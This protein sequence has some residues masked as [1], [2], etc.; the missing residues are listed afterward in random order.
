[1]SETEVDTILLLTSDNYITAEYDSQLDK[2][3]RYEEVS[4]QNITS[5]EIGMYQPPKLFPGSQSSFLC[6]RINY[7]VNDVDGFF[8]MFRSP[9]IRFFN[10]VAVVIKKPEE[11][12]ESL[13]SI[14]EFYRIALDT[15]GRTDVQIVTG[16]ALSRRKSRS[17]LLGVSS[18]GMPRNLS[19]SQL[20][21]V[22]SK[23]V[24]SLAGQFSKLGKSLKSKSTGAK[25]TFQIGKAEEGKRP[26][27]FSSGSDDGHVSDAEE[28]DMVHDSESIV[29]DNDFLPSVG[30]VMAG[31]NESPGTDGDPAILASKNSMSKLSS[32]VCTSAIS[33][34]TDNIQMPRR[35][36]QTDSPV[37]SRSRSPNPEIRVDDGENDIPDCPN[38][39]KYS[40]SSTDFTNQKETMSSKAGLSKDLKLNL[41]TSHSD[42]ALKQLKSLTSPFSKIAKG[43]QSIGVNL[44]PRKIGARTGAI[45]SPTQQPE[46]IQEDYA[47]KLQNMWAESGCKTKLIAL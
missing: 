19:E 22:G 16:G 38:T 41:S 13:H 26:D 12:H 18:G 30:I 40:T 37:R 34:I 39:V 44:D 23:A 28:A 20:V 9:N 3:V 45:L 32:D 17:T 31:K 36:L 4:L 29:K 7:N 27:E 42:N 43:V 21:Q 14:V 2:I 25:A 46:A 24:S 6:I 35:M 11:I 10:N 15:I 33:S 8:H 47:E 5:I 1:M